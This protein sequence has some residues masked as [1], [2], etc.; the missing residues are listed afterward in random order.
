M[1]SQAFRLL[2]INLHKKSESGLHVPRSIQQTPLP[3]VHTKDKLLNDVKS[4]CYAPDGYETFLTD[5]EES[6]KSNFERTMIF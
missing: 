6:L 3:V 4:G 5:R 1:K 2:P